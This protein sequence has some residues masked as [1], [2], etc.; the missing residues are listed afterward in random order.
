M[1]VVMIKRLLIGW[2]V[3]AVFDTIIE[4]AENLARR[5]DTTIDDQAV[6]KFKNHRDK[7]IALAKGKL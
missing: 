6:Q 1:G 5:S 4:L 3:E 7:F 2:L